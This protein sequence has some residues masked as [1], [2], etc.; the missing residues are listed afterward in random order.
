MKVAGRVSALVCLFLLVADIAFA[1]SRNIQI[2]GRVTDRSDQQPLAGANVYIKGTTQGGATEADGRFRINCRIDG[3]RR[4]IVLVSS[5][6]GYAV[7]EKKI[8]LD[9]RDHIQVDFALQSEDRCLENVLVT[10]TRA[11]HA[12]VRTPVV[13][14]LIKRKDIERIAAPS[15]KEL[16]EYQIPG[17]EFS[18]HGGNISVRMQGFESGYILFLIDGEEVSGQ[19]NGNI[20]L[21]RLTPEQIE[22]VEVIR[23]AGSA[24]YGS[25]AVAGVINIITKNS[26]KPISALAS[27]GY[28]EPNHFTTYGEL[29]CQTKLIRSTTSLSYGNAAEYRLYDK[30]KKDFQRI[31]RDQTYRVGEKLQWTPSDVLRIKANASYSYRLQYISDYQR[32]TNGSISG[33]LSACYKK[34]EDNSYTFTANQD[35]TKRGVAFPKDSSSDST[36]YTNSLTMFRLQNDRNIADKFS[37]N[38]GAEYHLEGMRSFQIS[39]FAENKYIHS[40]VAFVQLSHQAMESLTLLYGIRSDLH[41]DYGVHISPKVGLMYRI[42]KINIRAGYAHA[43]KAP[44]ITELNFDWFHENGPGF[45]ITGNKNLKPETANQFTLSGEYSRRDFSA[46]VTAHHTSFNRKIV[47]LQDKS[48]NLHYDNISGVSPLGGI[49]ANMIWRPISSFRL[50]TNY[51]YVYERSTVKVKDQ[52]VNVSSVRPHSLTAQLSY[53][54]SRRNYQLDAS[55]MGRYHSRLNTSIVSTNSETQE[56]IAEPI[57]Y[58]GYAILRLAV[59]QRFWERY[60]LVLGIDN[61][62]DYATDKVS[63]LAPLSPGRSF[64]GKVS[65]TL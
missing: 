33:Y 29:G 59:N 37:L 42:G 16:L 7:S 21:T 17:V 13:T 64:F 58:E 23:G 61:L 52:D 46:S 60:S 40:G 19:N 9:K 34:D 63:S 18:T 28:S 57:S 1:Q 22:R 65:I 38:L 50:S 10:A 8:D 14:Q 5:M 55:I 35:Y 20:D 62:L 53:T 31:P 56:R 11:E 25:N 48:G 47:M 24:L 32:N 36:A 26:N 44:T 54:F 3:K 43:F 12:L 45:K 6:L 49:E 15:I 27:V 30:D 2:S 39:N 41:S 51:A 4:Q